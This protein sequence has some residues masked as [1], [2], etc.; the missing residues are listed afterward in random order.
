MKPIWLFFK[1]SSWTA[2]KTTCFFTSFKIFL[3]L[4]CYLPVH[5]ISMYYVFVICN[6]PFAGETYHLTNT[7]KHSV[8]TEKYNIFSAHSHNQTHVDSFWF[9]YIYTRIVSAHFHFI[10]K[11]H[12]KCAFCCTSKCNVQFCTCIYKIRT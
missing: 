6:N 7:N 2:M 12:S 3:S 9:T 5:Y 10:R 4:C 1:V 11:I 8:K